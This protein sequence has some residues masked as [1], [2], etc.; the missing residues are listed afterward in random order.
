MPK[1]NRTDAELRAQRSSYLRQYR[2]NY[3][4]THP[5]EH[6]ES[7][8]RARDKY[9]ADPDKSRRQRRE[10]GARHR[11]KKRDTGDTSHAEACRKW[12]QLNPDKYAM[13]SREA[14]IK[15][16]GIAL[17]TYIRK[18]SRQ[19]GRCAVCG[20]VESDGNAYLQADIGADSEVRGLLCRTCAAGLKGFNKDFTLLLRAAEYLL[21]R[22]SKTSTASAS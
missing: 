8:R 18:Y 12:R 2:Q 16:Q 13:A 21:G 5:A 14:A 7:C 11:A 19:G 20:K 15:K 6:A 10:A 22:A 1:K 3:R 17:D 4:L 9:W